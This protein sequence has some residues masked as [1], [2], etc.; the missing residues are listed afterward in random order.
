MEWGKIIL[1]VGVVV[2]AVYLIPKITSNDSENF[3]GNTTP[4]VLNIATP[5]S[6]T[7]TTE[8]INNP[9]S[10]SGDLSAFS[11][12]FAEKKSSSMNLPKGASYNPDVGVYLSPSGMGYSVAPSLVENFANKQQVVIKKSSPITI[13]T[14]NLIYNTIWGAK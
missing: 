13:P 2:G 11:S 14:N 7:T 12:L 6:T 10:S 4:S 9:S 1:G 5:K 8:T 3:S